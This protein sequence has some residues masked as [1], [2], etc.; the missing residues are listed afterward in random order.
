MISH[1]KFEAGIPYDRVE[2]DCVKYIITF[3][4]VIIYCLKP[5]ILLWYE[6][7]FHSM[8]TGHKYSAMFLNLCV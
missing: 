4:S 3:I 8:F 2:V 1:N 7:R 5:I 6:I